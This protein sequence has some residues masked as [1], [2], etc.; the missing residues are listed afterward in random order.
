[1]TRKIEGLED[2]MK[3]FD[4]ASKNPA[5]KDN[6]LDIKDVKKFFKDNYGKFWKLNVENEKGLYNAKNISFV[7]RNISSII[8][9]YNVTGDALQ[10]YMGKQGLADDWNETYKKAEL[11]HEKL[12]GINAY[13]DKTL[14]SAIERNLKAGNVLAAKNIVEGIYEL[15][16]F[17][18][19]NYN[20]LG[21]AKTRA[22]EYRRQLEEQDEYNKARDL[23]GM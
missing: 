12:G 1:M 23:R 13:S 3:K 22:N 2:L 14:E 21:A 7:Y 8:E 5:W 16:D 15:A 11:I 6:R 9:K 10:I 20:L 19:G 18:N 4:S 17:S